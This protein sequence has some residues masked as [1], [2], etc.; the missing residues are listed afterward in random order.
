[1]RH[2]DAITLAQALTAAT[3]REWAPARSAHSGWRCETADA[4]LLDSAVYRTYGF[5]GAQLTSVAS[6]GLQVRGIEPGRGWAQ[7]AAEKVAEM[8]VPAEVVS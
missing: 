8:M 3:G 1:M 6:L 5:S 7:R 2:R 4:P